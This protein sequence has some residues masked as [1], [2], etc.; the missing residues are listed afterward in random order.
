M[1]KEQERQL[2]NA[3]VG[4]DDSFRISTL[5]VLQLAVII[6]ECHCMLGEGQYHQLSLY[7]TIIVMKSIYTINSVKV[8]K[9]LKRL[10]FLIL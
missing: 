10:Q 2:E 6:L 1:E 8:P 5:L 9:A 4:P 7:S 3:L